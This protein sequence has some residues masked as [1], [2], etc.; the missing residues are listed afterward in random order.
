[1]NDTRL[2]YCILLG[3]MIGATFT[4]F[5]LISKIHHSLLVGYRG[6]GRACEIFALPKR[7]CIING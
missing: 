4:A 5:L 7:Q 2:I 1:M 6:S 3:Y